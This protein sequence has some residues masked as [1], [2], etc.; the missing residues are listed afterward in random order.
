MAGG[1]AVS[2]YRRD[3]KP[4][5]KRASRVWAW[6][7][8][9][10]GRVPEKGMAGQGRQRKNDRQADRRANDHES[11]LPAYQLDWAQ[12]PRQSPRYMPSGRQSGSPGGR[13][14][15]CQYQPNPAWHPRTHTTPAGKYFVASALPRPPSRLCSQ[16][17]KTDATAGS[18][19]ARHQQTPPV[20]QGQKYSAHRVPGCC[21][22]QASKG[23][24]GIRRHGS[25]I[26]L[27]VVVVVAAYSIFANPGWW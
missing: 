7:R 23:Q 14:L 19:S 24:G 26:E 16:K 22:R 17:K 1:R 27:S 12:G 6:R 25:G 4:S 9:R 20:L 11:S 2:E 3:R 15:A 10:R 21:T 8:A 5:E 18:A 13:R